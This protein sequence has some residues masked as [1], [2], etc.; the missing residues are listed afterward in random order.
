MLLME[1]HH[2][3]MLSPKSQALSNKTS[4]LS[5]RCEKKKEVTSPKAI[6]A[7]AT[8]LGFLPGKTRAEENTQF[9]RR[10]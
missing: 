10:T 4:V 8:A 1:L 5:A 9:G 7:I 6:W 3:V 2:R